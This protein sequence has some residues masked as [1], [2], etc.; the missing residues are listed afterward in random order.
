MTVSRWCLSPSGEYIAGI[1]QNR[2][3]VRNLPFLDVTFSKELPVEFTTKAAFIRWSP[4]I[5]SRPGHSSTPSTPKVGHPSQSEWSPIQGYTGLQR[6][7]S[8]TQRILLADQDVVRVFDIKQDNWSAVINAAAGSIGK[9]YNVEFGRTAEEILIFSEHNV[10]V[11]IWSLLTARCIEVKDPK[12]S[13]K[14]FEYRPFTGHLAL[15]AR[16]GPQDLI[17]LHHP[18]SYRLIAAVNVPTTDAQGLKWSHD[19]RWFVVWDS[20]SSGCK[21]LVYTADGNLYRTYTDSSESTSS[22]GLGI[23]SI[24]WS[25][26]GDHL[27]VGNFD[28]RITLLSSYTFTPAITFDHGTT[29]KVA[30]VTVYQEILE[31]SGERR[32]GVAPQ[33]ICPPTAISVPTDTVPKT[34][35]SIL[36]FSPDQGKLLAA[37]CE[38]TPTTLW[39]WDLK[40]IS[41]ATILVQHSPIKTVSWHPIVHDLLL[42]T[43]AQDENVIYLWCDRWESPRVITVPVSRRSGRY[44]ARWVRTGEVPLNTPGS[45][46]VFSTSHHSNSLSLVYGDSQEVVRGVLEETDEVDFQRGAKL[47][48]I[49]SERELSGDYFSR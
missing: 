41:P 20:A 46:R 2:L 37:K 24:E 25:T 42:F 11:T 35:I 12:F 1:V 9:I 29:I 6:S 28:R 21:A 31:P 8:F 36:A 17:T 23:R 39:I 14:G 32:Y 7:Q 22:L 27:A 49:E 45:D 43:C 48:V 40:T 13:S 30:G 26:S 47:R 34:G 15:L 38:V 33:P 19:G 16:P 10:K 44:D 18:S 3:I 5:S 4:Q